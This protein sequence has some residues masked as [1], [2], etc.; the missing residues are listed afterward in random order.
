MCNYGADS[1]NRT[2]TGKTKYWQILSWLA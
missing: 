2:A 1:L